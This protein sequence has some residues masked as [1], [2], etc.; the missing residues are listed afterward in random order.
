MHTSHLVT[1]WPGV[2]M[3]DSDGPL[4]CSFYDGF[5]VVRGHIVINLST[6]R[7]VT[8]QQHFRLLDIVDQKLPEATGQ[9]PL[10]F[11]VSN[12][13]HQDPNNS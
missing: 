12:A 1:A 13:G 7:F 6:V 2:G 8:H 3:G 10:G 9:H 4:C 5:S 11:L